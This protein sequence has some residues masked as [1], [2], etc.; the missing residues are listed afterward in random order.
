MKII[1][2]IVGICAVIMFVLSYQM[3]SRK[4]IVLCNVISRVLY[5][6]QYL[7]LGA[8]EGAV[9]DIVGVL[10]SVLAQNKD[11]K[12][13]KKYQTAVI[14][15]VN[16]VIVAAGLLLYENVFSL[17]PMFGVL[18]HTGAFWFSNEKKIRFMSFAGSP[19]WFAYNL[20]SGAYGSSIG[21]V[22]TMVSIGLAIYRYDI[23]KKKGE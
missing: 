12:F 2:N 11:S 10:A 4:G 16:V 22:M 3:K 14:I 21:D 1:A 18:L 15:G 19:F 17:L 8:F 5:V 20:Y 13:I 6:A 7:L 23:R 9:L